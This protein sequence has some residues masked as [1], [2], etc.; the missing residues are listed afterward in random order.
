MH[1]LAGEA[2]RLIATIETSTSTAAA[3][4]PVFDPDRPG[5]FFDQSRY[6]GRSSLVTESLQALKQRIP[7]VLTGLPGVGKTTL[8]QLVVQQALAEHVFPDGLLWISL[9]PQPQIHSEL[10]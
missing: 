8:A 4:Y 7:Y 10:Q 2:G 3:V 9:G 5:F 6:V 1:L